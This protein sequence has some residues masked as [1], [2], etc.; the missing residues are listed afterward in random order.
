M[1][2][3]MISIKN[4]LKGIYLK[5]SCIPLSIKK[6]KRKNTVPCNTAEK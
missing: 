2:F 4:A 5:F 1:R 6:K 3:Q